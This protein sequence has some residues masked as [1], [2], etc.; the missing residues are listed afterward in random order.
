MQLTTASNHLFRLA[1]ALSAAAVLAFVSS[2]ASADL[3]LQFRGNH[4]GSVAQE[5]SGGTGLEVFTLDSTSGAGAPN[6]QFTYTISG[7]DAFGDGTANDSLTATFGVASAGGNVAFQND[8]NFGVTGN[9]AGNLNAGTESLTYSLV[10]TSL[11]FGDPGTGAVTGGGFTQIRFS[12][13]GEGETAVLSGGTTADG[14]IV[15]PGNGN[16]VF[17]QVDSFTIGHLGGTDTSN[18][19]VGPA[20]Y[21]FVITAEAAAI[22]EPSA[23][24][25]SLVGLAVIGLRRRRR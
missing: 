24:V 11:A 15:G 22:P 12:Q 14:N 10:N 23:A 20:R 21:R 6:A 9:N 25:V 8:G 16:T 7:L 1:T 18:F 19:R 5:T 3:I 13:F 4:D 2:T 17:S